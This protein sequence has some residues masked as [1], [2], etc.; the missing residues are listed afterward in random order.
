MHRRWHIKSR[1]TWNPKTSEPNHSFQ[2]CNT[3]PG[4]GNRRQGLQF[5]SSESTPLRRPVSLP[6]ALP[7][8]S[9][10]Y[11][12]AHKNTG[13]WVKASSKCAQCHLMEKAEP[14]T[15]H[16]GVVYRDEDIDRPFPIFPTQTFRLSLTHV[17]F[18]HVEEKTQWCSTKAAS[19]EGEYDLQ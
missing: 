14:V 18:H 1:R 2:Q 12:P 19:R 7:E 8:P 9:A 4:P 10:F 15:A 5:T 13:L 3:L 11:L 17:L 6:F 16:R